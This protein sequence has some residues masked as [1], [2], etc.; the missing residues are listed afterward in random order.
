VQICP[1]QQ[2][3]QQ[4]R[5]FSLS[6]RTNKTQFLDNAQGKRR[7]KALKGRCFSG[8]QFKPV[9]PRVPAFKKERLYT[10]QATFGKRNV[11]LAPEK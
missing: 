4:Y 11:L 10:A 3:R 9:R 6:K 5:W 7:F 8:H 2:D 1:R